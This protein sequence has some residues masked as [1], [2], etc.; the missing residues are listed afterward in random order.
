MQPWR[1]SICTIGEPE[2]Q[3]NLDTPPKYRIV[4]NVTKISNY[5]ID[6]PVKAYYGT[7]A[8]YSLMDKRAADN[9][10]ESLSDSGENACWV[11]KPR[12][13]ATPRISLKV[14]IPDATTYLVWFTT[15][16]AVCTGLFLF[17]V[18][19]S[20][21]SDRL[22]DLTNGT[23]NTFRNVRNLNQAPS[24]TAQASIRPR[25]LTIRQTRFVC[26]VFGRE[27]LPSQERNDDRCDWI[28]SI[29]L[30]EA[31]AR[32]QKT[33]RTVLL[34]CTHRF[35]RAC[36]RHWL[37][38]GKPACPLCQWDVRQL[39]NEDGEPTQFIVDTSATPDAAAPLQCVAFV[40]D[41][42]AENVLTLQP[43]DHER[44]TQ[45]VATWQSL[46]DEESVSSVRTPQPASMRNL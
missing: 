15:I 4:A 25:C 9:A 26:N 40:R 21:V 11:F 14:V 31:D 5:S 17:F 2:I 45:G 36:I 29:C 38:K 27:W 33:I 46:N 22:Y 41:D 10:Y 1:E 30:E 23:N 32:T 28:C 42:A 16:V 18:V 3:E 12:T 6:Q 20:R 8:S 19:V 35:H 7:D 43:A 37:R 44:F 34:P 39:F 24:N 13:E